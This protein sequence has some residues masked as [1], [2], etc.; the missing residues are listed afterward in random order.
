MEYQQILLRT[1]SEKTGHELN[2]FSE[3]F[4][5]KCG[6]LAGHI[7]TAPDMGPQRQ[8]TCCSQ[9]ANAHPI[10]KRRIGGSSNRQ[11]KDWRRRQQWRHHIHRRAWTKSS[12]GRMDYENT[13]QQ[14]RQIQSNTP[15]GF[16][17]IFLYTFLSCCSAVLAMKA[18]GQRAAGR[19]IP[20]SVNLRPVAPRK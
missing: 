9:S 18:A 16:C 20:D 14:N 8:V 11:K 2:C 17:I 10:G 1:A 7:L 13:K 3:N 19:R 5:N 4:L 6:A 15:N 12:D